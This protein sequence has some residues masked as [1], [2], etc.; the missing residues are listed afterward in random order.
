MNDNILI[1]SIIIFL[2]A[3]GGGL[4]PVIR[5]WSDEFLHLF[6]SFGAGVFLG[7]VFLHLLPEA[8]EHTHT[9]LVPLMVLWDFYLFS[10]WK[11]SCS[12]MVKMVM[13]IVIRLS[14]LRH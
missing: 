11:G 4:I 2:S 8:L 10:F 14:Q 3:V 12:F 13:T 7:M 1:Y 9:K 5:Q 6:L